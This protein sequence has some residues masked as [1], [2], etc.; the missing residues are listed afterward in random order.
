MRTD[1]IKGIYCSAGDGEPPVPA[2][3]VVTMA[4]GNRYI[5]SFIPYG[6]IENLLKPKLEGVA[7][8]WAKNL[9]FVPNCK[10]D[11]VEKV[12]RTM[13]DEGEVGEVF[14]KI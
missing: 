10:P 3:V 14:E 7:Y 2:D 6:C 13:V 11:T 8:F 1:S 9:V 12:V 5:A 4:S